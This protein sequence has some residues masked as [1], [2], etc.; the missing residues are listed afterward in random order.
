MGVRCTYRWSIDK[1]RLASSVQRLLLTAGSLSVVS[2]IAQLLGLG[3]VV[4]ASRLGGVEQFG[5][6]QQFLAAVS[7]ASVLVQL[8]YPTCLMHLRQP[9]FEQVCSGIVIV[10]PLVALILGVVAAVFAGIPLA[11]LMAV[12]ALGAA[13]QSVCETM[14]FRHN[15]IK[16]VSLMRLLGVSLFLLLLCLVITLGQQTLSGLN[17]C[18]VYTASSIATSWV[19]V[20]LQIRFGWPCQHGLKSSMRALWDY[21]SSPFNLM[22]SALLNVA[23]YSLPILLIGHFF[24]PYWSGQYG[25]VLRTSFA[26][27]NL[28]AEPISKMVHSLIAMQ[29]RSLDSLS[30]I[31]I[32]TLDKYLSLASVLLLFALLLLPPWLL[33]LLFGAQWAPAALM[34][35]IM[36]PLFASMLWVTPLS[37]A[38]IVFDLH[39]DLLRAQVSYVLISVFAFVLGG[40]WLHNIW[41]AVA[42]F[43]MMSACRY[44][45]M[46]RFLFHRLELV[47]L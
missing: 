23:S 10:M 16:L 38:Y 28:L 47:T 42:A 37:S 22:P 36:S 6:Y 5:I 7:L 24:G 12:A 3:G 32:K 35:Q 46:R 34:V 13:Y 11:A 9:K 21:R 25:L 30:L 20:F 39:S 41:I 4:L 40:L 8:G 2:A 18:I 15:R 19:Y 44:V 29:R 14:A 31:T 43:A 27:I 17:L 33:P 26:P 45:L 1:Q